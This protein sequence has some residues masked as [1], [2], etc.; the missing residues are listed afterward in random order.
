M[1]YLQS[2][3]F[4]V[5]RQTRGKSCL[6]LTLLLLALSVRSAELLLALPAVRASR[7]AQPSAVCALPLSACFQRPLDDACD[8]DR[9]S[10]PREWK[11]S[12]ISS[13]FSTSCMGGSVCVAQRGLEHREDQN[14]SLSLRI[15]EDCEAGEMCFVLPDPILTWFVEH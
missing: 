8:F 4:S 12:K 5:S 11:I 2:E 1:L 14:I 10:Q 7:P 3:A 13:S 9:S 6:L 15:C